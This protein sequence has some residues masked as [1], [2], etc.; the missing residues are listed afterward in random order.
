MIIA[1]S[2]T[3]PL[4]T[5]YGHAAGG[6]LPSAMFTSVMRSL[7]ATVWVPLQ[8]PMHRL[9]VFDGV[10]VLDGIEVCVGDGVGV[11]VAVCVAVAVGVSVS[12]AVGGAVSVGDGV[13]G[14]VGDGVGDAVAS[15][16]WIE[17]SAQ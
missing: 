13:G 1:T 8:S 4:G 11:S 14:S 10:G 5:P 17:M 3:A 12:V 2:T 15:A 7:T 6:A 16:P 9:G